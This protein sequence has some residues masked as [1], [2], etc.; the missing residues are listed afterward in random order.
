MLSASGSSLK[1]DTM[2]RVSEHSLAIEK[3]LSREERLC[4]HCPQ[5][6]ME[7]ELHFLTSCQM[8]DHIIDKHFSQITQT[9]E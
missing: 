9:H 4:A 7:T 8:Y 1:R 6:E 2:Y 3:E 5:N